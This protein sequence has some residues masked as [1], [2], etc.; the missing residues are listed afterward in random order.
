MRFA[1]EI[2]KLFL[3]VFETHYAMCGLIP[4]NTHTVYNPMDV[5]VPNIDIF[6]NSLNTSML[7]NIDNQSKIINSAARV[8]RAINSA[9]AAYSTKT[10]KK[11]IDELILSKEKRYRNITKLHDVDSLE[12]DIEKSYKRLKLIFKKTKGHGK[13]FKSYALNGAY[14]HQNPWT[15]KIRLNGFSLIGPIN[16]ELA[17]IITSEQAKIHAEKEEYKLPLQKSRDKFINSNIGQKIGTRINI[18]KYI[19]QVL[20]KEIPISRS[21][22]NEKWV[23]YDNFSKNLAISFN[24]LNMINSIRINKILDTFNV[25]RLMKFDDEAINRMNYYKEVRNFGLDK[26]GRKLTAEERALDEFNYTLKFPDVF[27]ASISNV[28][29]KK[30]II[31]FMCI[32]ILN[33]ILEFKEAPKLTT[34]PEKIQ[35]STLHDFKQAYVYALDS[36]D[37]LKYVSAYSF[38]NDKL[39]EIENHFAKCIMRYLKGEKK[40]INYLVDLKK[41]IDS[42]LSLVESRRPRSSNVEIMLSTRNKENIKTLDLISIYNFFLTFERNLC[43]SELA[44]LHDLV[45]SIP[46]IPQR[47]MY[48]SIRYSTYLSKETENRDII[49]EIIEKYQEKLKIF[50][51][52]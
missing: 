42:D 13:H 9:E 36:L 18:L 12:N 34:I 50:K 10:S 33:F 31:S 44:S 6:G 14:K 22:L 25:Q 29:Y 16:T 19:N 48:P 32:Q 27:K 39:Y 41:N 15:K 5:Q 38:D 37:S 26:T 20:D 8:A 1:K 43:D 49:D 7:N 11:T 24:M 4:N 51:I 28:K 23:I 3:I 30:T 47:N 52:Y 2:Y 21:F 45:N 17:S 46:N 40:I 35:T